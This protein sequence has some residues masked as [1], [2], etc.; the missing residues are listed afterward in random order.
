[1]LSK[2][3][4]NL[5]FN[6]SKSCLNLVFSFSSGFFLKRFVVSASFVLGFGIPFTGTASFVLTYDS[7]QE[8]KEKIKSKYIVIWE[9]FM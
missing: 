8:R 1:M 6:V 4:A 5:G 9:N 3:R 2:F 7:P